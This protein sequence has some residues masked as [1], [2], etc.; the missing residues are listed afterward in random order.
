MLKCGVMVLLGVLTM[1]AAESIARG[2]GADPASAKVAEANRVDIHSYAKPNQ[3]RVEHMTLY[4]TVDFE[5]KQLR[6]EAVLRYKRAS[7]AGKAALV[8]NR[9]ADAPE[10]GIER[11]QQRT[12]F[13]GLRG[14]IQSR[15]VARVAGGHFSR[16]PVQ[17]R[18]A[19][20]YRDRQIQRQ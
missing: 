12:H 8:L 3:V 1:T 11:R 15:Q 9:C 17:R 2:Q 4:L 10:Q 6:G 18:Q 5:A 14:V 16:Q 13:T 19:T 7:G 20:A